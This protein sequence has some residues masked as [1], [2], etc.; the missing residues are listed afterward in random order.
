VWSTFRRGCG[1]S[2]ASSA[3]W[4]ASLTSYGLKYSVGSQGKKRRPKAQ[5]QYA[6]CTNPRRIERHNANSAPNEKD[7]RLLHYGSATRCGAAG[8]QLQRVS[9][10][11]DI[12]A[13]AP[14]CTC[15]SDRNGQLCPGG[16]SS[17]SVGSLT[18]IIY[19]PLLRRIAIVGS[20]PHGL[21]ALNRHRLSTRM[22][23]SAECIYTGRRR[24]GRQL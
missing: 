16:A 4:R 24:A 2:E 23:W 15:V 19:Q 8:A 5:R 18:P 14:A 7:P 3:L 12:A 22:L 20:A 6:E 1:S 9:A 17:F 13:P 10:R 21:T 11:P